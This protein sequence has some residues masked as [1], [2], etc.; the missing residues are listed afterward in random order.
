MSVNFLVDVS[1]YNLHPHD[2]QLMER[3]NQNPSGSVEQK[4]MRVRGHL[5][6][7]L[8]AHHYSIVPIA[9]QETQ[10]ETIK[11]LKINLIINN[12]MHHHYHDRHH[13]FTVYRSCIM[14]VT[15]FRWRGGG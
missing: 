4:T 2:F 12:I 14:I 8:L 11:E 3:K 5:L 1:I 9:R 13:H 10:Y 6:D 7:R 15:F